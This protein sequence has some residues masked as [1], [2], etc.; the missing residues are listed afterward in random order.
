MTRITQQQS[1]KR[2][3]AAEKKGLTALVVELC[4]GHLRSFPDDR[5]ALLWFAMAKTELSQYSQSE[6]AIR[7]AIS[8][9]R[10]N[11][12]FL[13]LAFKQMGSLSDARGDLKSAGAWYRRALRANPKY[14]Y[15]IYLGHVAFKQG[16]LKKAESYYRKAIKH[17]ASC[18]DEAYF[19]L[20]GVLL[21]KRRYQEAIKCYR[22]ALKIDPNY[23]IAKKRLEDAELAL[24]F[25]NS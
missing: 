18:V 19:N 1:L 17:P 20:G 11:K 15:C 13:A 4:E 9:G 8:L 12:R 21:A 24:R 3:T 6:K 10:R 5:F 23:G 14:D 7:R 25:R 22:K 2:I 16:L